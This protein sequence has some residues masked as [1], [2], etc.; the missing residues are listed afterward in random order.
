MQFRDREI[1]AGRYYRHFKGGL[2]LVIGI[3]IHTETEEKMVV[4]QAQYGDKLLFVRPYRM[5][6]EQL[7]HREHPEAKQKYRFEL[8]EDP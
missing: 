7:D 6:A 1:L 8:A 3:A 2:Y 5:F 4:Y